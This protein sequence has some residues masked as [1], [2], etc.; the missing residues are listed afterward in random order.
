[1]GVNVLL[2]VV[3]AILVI[4]AYRG[5]R[6]GFLR[7]AFS[8]LSFALT[9]VIVSWA[10]PH[11]MNFL[12]DNTGIYEDL[13]VA[14]EQA[15]DRMLENGADGVGQTL[16]DSS[17]GIGEAME[18]S[19]DGM[20]QAMGDSADGVGQETEN[21]ADGIGQ[22]FGDGNIG[23]IGEIQGDWF[24]QDSQ[25]TMPVGGLLA[26]A[27]EKGI[28]AIARML[29]KGIS[30]FL[31]FAVVSIVLQLVVGLLDIVS[32]IPIIRGFNRLMGAAA[33]LLQGLL[34]VW[35]LMLL[36]AL[37]CTTAFGQQLL[38]QIQEN[39]FLAW[40]FEKDVFLKFLLS[41]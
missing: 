2:V 21:G 36:V 25:D 33:G 1:M 10:V 4:A 34:A 37:A 28:D 26:T 11:V 9:L 35:L 24:G 29:L 8:L 13:R 17:D 7:M 40:L 14:C 16:G 30:F 18:D 31:S 38:L 41:L 15:V 39:A 20:G 19:A 23:N 22:S 5:Y 6:R 12:R 3:L 27:R 32:R